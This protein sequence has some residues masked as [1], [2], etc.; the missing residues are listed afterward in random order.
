MASTYVPSAG[1]LNARIAIVGE[2]PG[3][4]EVLHKHLG[5]FSGPAGRNLQECLQIARIPWSD[6]YRTNVMK[7][8][9]SPLSSY[10]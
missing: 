1:P 9:D 4:N 7:D 3:R 2:Q 8:L 10:I 6:I 5:P